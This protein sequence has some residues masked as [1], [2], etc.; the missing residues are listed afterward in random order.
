MVWGITNGAI[1][2]IAAALALACTR[3]APSTRECTG[4][5]EYTLHVEIPVPTPVD[6]LFV[7]DNSPGMAA[8]MANLRAHLDAF[9]DAL[10]LDSN[11]DIHVG[12]ITTDVECNVP[13]KDCAGLTSDSCCAMNP[14]VCIDE[15]VDGDGITDVSNCDGGR[16]RAASTGRRIFS[17]P[18]R[19]DWDAWKQEFDDLLGHIP[20]TGSRFASGLEAVRRA[21]G[22]ATAIECDARDLAVA[23]LNAGFI[24]ARQIG[25]DLRNQPGRLQPRRPP[26]LRE[27][28]LPR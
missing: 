22:C 20:M 1:G 27:A 11:A 2:A 18:H 6:I 19:E 23:D 13:T 26:G 10:L 9:G 16:L 15:D 21:V 24:R 25:P 17:G 28:G 4:V 5:A 12:V 14:I 7:I 8:E 3:S